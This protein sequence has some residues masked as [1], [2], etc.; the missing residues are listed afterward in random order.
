MSHMKF[1]RS[2]APIGAGLVC[3]L[4]LSAC[5]GGGDSGSSNSSA[6]AEGV[7]GGTMTGSNSQ[8]FQLLVLENGEFWGMYGAQTT[9]AFAVAGF[10][11]GSGSSLSGAYASSNTRDFGSTPA[12]LGVTAATY[13]AS[14]K[15]I[16]GSV[17]FSAGKVSFSGGPIAGTLYD[18]NTPASLSTVAGAWT[19]NGLNGES[20]ALTIAA[21][22]TFSATS[23]L[24]CKFSGT[25]SPRASG[26]NVFNVNLTFGALPCALPNQSASGI[27]VAY[28]LASGKTQLL[29]AVVDS[30]RTV[31]TAGFGTR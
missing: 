3:A 15:T 19:L 23:G 10:V 24:G 9:S 13:D 28:P 27:A 30:T 16:S 7:Y 11:Q 26:K 18:Y 29:V 8:A 21:G 22:G 2:L 31:G 17:A 1:W 12:Q 14:A 20:I 5:G 6:T 4:G 25:V